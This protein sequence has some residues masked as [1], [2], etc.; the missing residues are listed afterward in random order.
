MPFITV[1]FT[2][3]VPVHDGAELRAKVAVIGHADM[4]G[5]VVYVVPERVPPHP[6]TVAE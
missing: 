1:E 4:M 2:G 5:A 3:R 6:V